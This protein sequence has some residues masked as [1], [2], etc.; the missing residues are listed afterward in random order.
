MRAFLMG[1]A[2]LLAFSLQNAFAGEQRII[3]LVDGSVLTGEVVSM[4][5]GIYT[6]KSNDLG[7][8][9]IED[10]KIKSIKSKDL[11]ESPANKSDTETK[12]R[13]SGLQKK[14]LSDPE[15]MGR[16]LSLK[17]DPKF[18]AVL[19]D[20]DVMTAIKT[21]NIAALLSNPN[22]MQLLDDPRVK[23]LEKKMQ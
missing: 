18:K 14:M 9:K 23:E 2:L 8:L 16:I 17:D 13:L 5:N 4:S 15:I 3:E 12:D 19:Q 22:F 1:T 10:L 20:P 6:I 7:T 11:V 21:G